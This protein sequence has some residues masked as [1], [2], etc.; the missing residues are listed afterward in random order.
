MEFIRKNKRILALAA[1]AVIFFFVYSYLSFK[2]ERVFN[3]PDETANFYFSKIFAKEGRLWQSEPLEFLSGNSIFPRSIK[4]IGGKLVP[5]GFLGMPVVY[6]A[7]AKIIGIGSIKFLTPF[8]AVLAVL[9]FYGIL[10]RIFEEKIAFFSAILMFALPPFWYYAERG[11]FHNVL[12]LSFLIFSFY[13][14]QKAIS[15]ENAHANNSRHSR[16]ICVTLALYSLGGLFLALTL[17]TRMS[18]AWWIMP[19]FL[20]LAIVVDSP[21]KSGN[22]R[23]N[24]RGIFI[25]GAMFILVLIPFLAQNQ[26]L[27]GSPFATGYANSNGSESAITI[28]QNYLE[29]KEDSFLIFPFGINVK[30]ILWSGWN[31]FIMFF[32][33]LSFPAIF[34]AIIFLG[35]IPRIRR[36]DR[37][38]TRSEKY[39]FG[40]FCFTALWLFV[41][42]GS[43]RFSD[44]PDPSKITIGTSYLRYWLPVFVM[45]LPFFAKFFVKLA[46]F[47]RIKFYKIAALIAI[48]FFVLS[49][50]PVFYAEGEGIMAV[51]DTLAGY[52]SRA[53]EVFNLTESNSIIIT[54]RNDKMFFPK[55]KIIYPLRSENTYQAVSSLLKF[56][57]VYY[58][59]IAISEKEKFNNLKLEL[60][61]KWENEALYKIEN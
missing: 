17:M 6:G 35:W 55:R 14:T 21:N 10:R 24:W 48:A 50:I 59:G 39:Y 16:K 13:C 27:Y 58:Y 5:V 20:F 43:W 51:K 53:Q 15:R 7:I 12:F 56:I 32:P 4:A 52:E 22:D 37:R 33:W 61:K 11:M 8:F 2:T 29:A 41:Y 26:I 19:V 18:E 44:N 25:A 54:D 31:Y 46:E 3:S 42:Y 60:V 9:A 36:A 28:A 40:I 45:I 57:P 47:F 38:M 34:G 49:F 1:M 23:H 30:N